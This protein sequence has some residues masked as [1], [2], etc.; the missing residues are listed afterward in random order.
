MRPLLLHMENFGPYAGGQDVDFSLLAPGTVFLVTGPT[1]AGKTTIFD[2]LCYALYDS[3]SGGDRQ[4]DDLRSLSAA[5]DA[6][7]RVRLSFEVKGARYEVFRQ[8]RQ[9]VLGARGGMTEA[10]GRVELTM[11]DGAALTR[12]A[13]ADEKIKGL[14]GLDRE[15]FK[16]IVMLA[17]GE[18]RELLEAKSSE[19][20]RILG[21]LFGT[22]ALA[23]LTQK[24]KARSV[25]AARALEDKKLEIRTE[26]YG[27][28]A[29]AGGA[30]A[31]A[32][33]ENAP[34]PELIKG[35]SAQARDDESAAAL[36][37]ERREALLKERA[38]ISFD[39]AENMNRRL[40]RLAELEKHLAALDAEFAQRAEKL[41]IRERVLAV[42]TERAALKKEAEK[43]GR[44]LAAQEALKKA[45]ALWRDERDA[46]TQKKERHLDAYGRFLAGQAAALAAG[47]KEGEACPVCGSREHPSPAAASGS[48]VTEAEVRRLSDEAD[49]AAALA[50]DAKGRAA[51]AYAAAAAM[52]GAELPPEE[53]VFSGA[54]SLE[55]AVSAAKERAD[56]A[57]RSIAALTEKA[58]E[59]AA[60]FR[61]EDR[62]Y[63]AG[64]LASQTEKVNADRRAAENE[65]AA[66]RSAAETEAAVLRAETE[67]RGPADIEGLKARSAAL[68]QE[69]AE[70][71]R[72]YMGLSAR[73]AQGA[74]RARAA[75]E[76]LTELSGL[77]PAAT[78]WAEL[79][80]LAAGD[81]GKKLPFETYALQQYFDGVIALANLRFRRMSGGRYSFVRR[82]ETGRGYAGLDLDV[83]C[84]FTG[85]TR[86]AST[87]SGG[88]GFMAS[89]SLALGLADMVSAT[90]G[91]VRVDTLFIDEGF[92]SLDPDALDLAVAAICT[93]GQTGR[94]V[95]LISHVPE[96]RERIAAKLV[97]ESERGRSRAHFEL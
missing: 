22:G 39:E 16:K 40:A 84:S 44:T 58:R 1:G 94:T 19:K 30:F 17:Q 47:L 11:P 81:N 4:N 66:A 91:A 43:R 63:D 67:G 59:L 14:I 34:A 65:H 76:K 51:G 28:P 56:E 54:A 75:E 72:L 9:T 93:I 36:Q 74:E 27:A 80:R 23:A 7:C 90:S 29:A 24:L 68:E 60:A 15:Q 12:K 3:P 53:E 41:D 87:L 62:L 73:A 32:R 49:R 18:F 88:E 78:D 50:A 97:V 2:A 13:E 52:E 38:S 77:E 6:L 45:L 20:Q 21:D 61:D 83:A 31:Q 25:A 26:L 37:K 35:L 57:L 71:E 5:P 42:L 48:A 82:Q 69:A 95:G 89:L 70:A 8:P 96:L 33:A 46:A 55:G 10:P 86:P 92:G 85:Q 79:Y 64:F